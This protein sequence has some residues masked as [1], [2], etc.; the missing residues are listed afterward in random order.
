MTVASHMGMSSRYV[1]WACAMPVLVWRSAHGPPGQPQNHLM[2]WTASTFQV[3]WLI[4]WQRLDRDATILDHWIH[5]PSPCP[6]ANI[7]LSESRVDCRGFTAT[8][9][10][11]YHQSSFG[12]YCHSTHQQHKSQLPRQMRRRSASLLDNAMQCPLLPQRGSYR[13]KAS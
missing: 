8:V 6:Q 11:H 10:E 4:Y 2:E 12:T 5:A 3:A 13:T 7:L 9:S 1:Q